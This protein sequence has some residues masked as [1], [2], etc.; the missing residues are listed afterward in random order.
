VLGLAPAKNRAI[1]LG[2]LKASR[3][4][5]AT[6]RTVEGLAMGTG[7]V[8]MIL[9]KPEVLLR[10]NTLTQPD[11][12]R[13]AALFASYGCREDAF[14]YDSTDLEVIGDGEACR[15]DYSVLDTFAPEPQYW[16]R[17]HHTVLVTALPSYI[18]S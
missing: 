16:H 7:H 9:H 12:A 4:P 2:E 13:L 11:L 1:L 17:E 5:E 8:K 10:L 3:Q 18:G 14:D 6:A 15:F